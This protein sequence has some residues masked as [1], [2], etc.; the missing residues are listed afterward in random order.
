MADTQTILIAGG[1][2]LIG[3]KLQQRFLAQGHQVRLLGRGNKGK[4]TEGKFYWDPAKGE[5]DETAF[6]GVT[7]LINLAGEAV[8]GPKW[9]EN[10]RQ[11]I[12][13]SRVDST[14]LLWQTAQRTGHIPHKVLCASAVGYYGSVT[15]DHIFTETDGP[16]KEFLSDVCVAWEDETDHFR[17]DLHVPTV[18]LRIGVVLAEDGGALQEIVK[19]MRKL[20]GAVLGSGKQWVPWIHIDDMVGIIHHTLEQAPVKGTYNAVAPTHA[21]FEDLT[22]AAANSLGKRLAPV[23][24]PGFAIALALGEQ[25]EI[26]LEGS[27]AS[28]D[29]IASTGYVF[30]FTDLQF[31]CDDLLKR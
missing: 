5:I 9:T 25:A 13:N 16:G 8:A 19:P 24:V 29:K 12:L 28:A 26:V 6:I 30:Q 20:M 3:H 22:K 18:T 14:R 10:R 17:T 11:A 1:S 27:R 2:G 4:E 15:V 21:N 7:W 31:A 23:N